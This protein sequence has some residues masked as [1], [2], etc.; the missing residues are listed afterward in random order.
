MPRPVASDHHPLAEYSAIHCSAWSL[1]SARAASALADERV[2]LHISWPD[3]VM[4]AT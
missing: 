2:I 4:V 3:K 1:A